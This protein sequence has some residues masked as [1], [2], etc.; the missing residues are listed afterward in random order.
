MELISS[1]F[2]NIEPMSALRSTRTQTWLVKATEE[3]VQEY[4]D[5]YVQTFMTN[6]KEVWV[7]KRGTKHEKVLSSPPNYVRTRKYLKAMLDYKDSLKEIASSIG[8]IQPE[9]AFFMWFLFP[10]PK[11]WTKKK[12]AA[13][14]MKLHK[15]RKDTDNLV[16]S[17]FDAIAPRKN[18]FSKDTDIIDDRIISSFACAK[19]YVP[20]DTQFGIMVNKYDISEFLLPFMDDMIEN[21]K[22]R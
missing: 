12:K 1:S 20:D 7:R 4:Q 17:F 9:D 8:Y 16:K 13:M 2:F 11:S 22:T 15:N 14:A 5:S 6:G 3:Y 18:S 21:L 19:L 10:M